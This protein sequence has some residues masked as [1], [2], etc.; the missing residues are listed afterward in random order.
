M[1]EQE[2]ISKIHSVYPTGKK[3]GLTN[4]RALM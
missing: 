4:M 2:A 3:N 1:T